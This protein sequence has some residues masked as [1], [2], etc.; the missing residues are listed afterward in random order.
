MMASSQILWHHAEEWI[1][2]LRVSSC[3]ILSPI[4]LEGG[5]LIVSDLAD[6]KHL[7][8][9]ICTL[10]LSGQLKTRRKQNL[11]TETLIL[12]ERITF[13][14]APGLQISSKFKETSVHQINTPPVRSQ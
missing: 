2:Q 11:E 14:L 7:L 9:G 1:I 10:E 5:C 13:N 12:P 6:F 4:T 8:C 3:A